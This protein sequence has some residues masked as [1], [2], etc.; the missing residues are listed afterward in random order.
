MLSKIKNVINRFRI[1][2]ISDTPLNMSPMI[3][4]AFCESSRDQATIKRIDAVFKQQEQDMNTRA[5]K[6]HSAHCADPDLCVKPK[7]YKWVPDK[8][9]SDSYEITLGDI[10]KEKEVAK[11]ERKRRMT[12][13]KSG[14]LE[15]E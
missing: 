6:P 2:K 10:I 11:K 12:R 13:L 8:I 15:K 4:T 3:D 7:C 5:L 14:I 1:I 9:V